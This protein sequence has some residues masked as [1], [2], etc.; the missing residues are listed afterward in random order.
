VAAAGRLNFR[1]GQ[2]TFAAREDQQLAP[3]GLRLGTVDADERA[4][5]RK[6]IRQ[7]Q[8]LHAGVGHDH[9]AARNWDRACPLLRRHDGLLDPVVVEALQI[10][11]LDVQ[12]R[13]FGRQR[14]T[15]P[16]AGSPLQLLV[17][18]LRSP[19]GEHTTTIPDRAN[20]RR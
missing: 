10:P 8:H 1:D 16:L 5:D 11:D 20:M 6:A 13:I 9:Q 3:A 18:Q 14:S 15:R 4:V 19:I 12:K 2:R 7:Q 17:G